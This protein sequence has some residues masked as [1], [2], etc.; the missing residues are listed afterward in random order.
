MAG[1]LPLPPEATVD[2]GEAL[3][4]LE[5]RDG[6]PIAAANAA[7]APAAAVDANDMSAGPPPSVSFRCAIYALAA[8][9]C[10]S[11]IYLLIFSF[12]IGLNSK[13]QLNSSSTIPS[14]A[15]QDGH[16]ISWDGAASW[17]PAS[18]GPKVANYPGKAVDCVENS[19]IR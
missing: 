10:T 18:V 15:E 13:L 2:N 1:P 12:S 14:H 8:L 6:E 19:T 16:Y 4:F 3:P 5:R 9:Y 7:R 17:R 11:Q